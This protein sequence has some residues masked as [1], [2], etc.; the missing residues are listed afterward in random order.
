M[1]LNGCRR[2]AAVAEQYMDI[3]QN[4]DI[5]ENILDDCR[6]NSEKIQSE[7]KCSQLDQIQKK[8]KYLSEQ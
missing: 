8:P 5:L 7:I 6:R 4:R 2:G 1:E 3:L